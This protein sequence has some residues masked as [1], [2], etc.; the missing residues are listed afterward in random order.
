M[1]NSE[2]PQDRIHIGKR[3]WHP[4]IKGQPP[5]PEVTFT[6]ITSGD[7]PI[8][9]DGQISRKLKPGEKIDQRKSWNSPQLILVA[10]NLEEQVHEELSR[11]QN[12]GFTEREIIYLQGL[13]N[14]AGRKRRA[15]KLG[16]PISDLKIFESLVGEKL[17]LPSRQDGLRVAIFIGVRDSL[18]NTD[19]LPKKQIDQLGVRETQ[20]LMA[21]VGGHTTAEVCDQLGISDR[22]VR[23]YRKTA[24]R[25]M[26]IYTG[27]QACAWVARDM[28]LR[29]Q[30]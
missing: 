6:E 18:L 30:L 9:T 14:G 3:P 10:R 21:M 22:S 25:K 28:K 19:F 16:I 5:G 15:S 12:N 11:V 4:P 7:A 29:G 20:V 2:I 23:T 26:G 24:Y 27:Y 13:V 8:I 17:G 1:S